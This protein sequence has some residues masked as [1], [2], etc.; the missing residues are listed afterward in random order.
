[1]QVFAVLHKWLVGVV[2]VLSLWTAS[3]DLGGAE[4]Q[5]A[6]EILASAGIPGGVVVHVGCGDGRLTAALRANDSFLVH[7]LD[8]NPANVDAA[9]KHLQS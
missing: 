7:G 8:A 2:S 4:Q 3:G 1:M 6:E 5:Q 9:R